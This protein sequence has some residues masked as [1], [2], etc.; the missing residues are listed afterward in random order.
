[1]GTASFGDGLS[2]VGLAITS[3][4]VILDVRPN[5]LIEFMARP[6]QG[7]TMSF[8]AGSAASFPV[9]LKLQRGGDQFTGSLSENGVDWQVV[10]TTPRRCGR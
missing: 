1:V 4:L 8:I 6:I 9:W 2:L 10:G 7:G 3:Q 5:G